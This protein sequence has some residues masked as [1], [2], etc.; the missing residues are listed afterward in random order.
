LAKSFLAG[1]KKRIALI[2]LSLSLVFPML[3]IGSATCQSAADYADDHTVI[4]TPA[5]PTGERKTVIVAPGAGSQE[6]N[7]YRLDTRQFTQGG[8]LDI[9]IAI[10][11]NSATDGSFDLFPAGT[12]IPKTGR[13]AGTIAGR[14]D[15]RRGTTT[16]L[17]YAFQTGQVFAFGLEGNWG[18]PRGATGNAT[19]RAS[20]RGASA[21]SQSNPVIK[22]TPA[23]PSTDRTAIITAP[24]RGRHA[25]NVVYI[26]L[27]NF[28]NA[29]ILDI[30][31]QIATNSNTDGS[32]DLFPSN[33]SLP[34][35][36][37]AGGPLTGRYDIRRGSSTRI[38]YRFRPG[39]VL[40]LGLEGNWFSA[41]G[42][43]GEVRFRATAHM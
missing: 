20:V 11:P 29:G 27:R 10:A 37:S 25:Y 17:E 4:L 42:S 34:P 1:K 26:D 22:L 23:E 41:A 30:D 28:A 14:Y 6:Y 16:R 31:I 18:S 3:A 12:P 24:G 38:E 43:T 8:V 15:I 9:D 33:S 39:Q 7:I 32:F 36:G 35:P 5:A 13:P 19:F 2:R 40:A 21:S